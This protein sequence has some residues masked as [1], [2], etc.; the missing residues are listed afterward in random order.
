VLALCAGVAIVWLAF[1]F[2]QLRAGHNSR[3][4]LATRGEIED[5]IKAIRSENTRLRETIALLETDKKIDSEA[6]GQIESQ[7]TSL[8]A[9]I[10]RQQEDLAFY[11]GIVSDQD[12][13]LRI[14]DLELFDGVDNLSFS[15]HLVLAQAMRADRRVKGFVEVNVE[16]TQDGELLILGLG[17]LAGKGNGSARL[18]FSFRY[19]QNLRA[20]LVLPEGFA[21][22]RVMVKLTPSGKSAKPVEKSFVWVTQAS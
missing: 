8:Q 20:N 19:F 14:Q 11:R 18:D 5:E 22:T 17:D 13:G 3:Q 12:T 4:A 9:E 16:G 10:L 7:L 1:E 6:Y 15:I 2:G 21:P